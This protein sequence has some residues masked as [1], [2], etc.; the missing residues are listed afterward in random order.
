MLFCTFLISQENEKKSGILIIQVNGLQSNKG[1]VMVALN[2]SEENYSADKNSAYKGVSTDI[3][4]KKATTTFSELPYGFYAVKVFHD[5]NNNDELDLNFVG[6][7]QEPYGF[8]NN[9]RGTFGPASWD[10]ARFEINSDS[11]IISITLE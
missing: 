2:N 8:S 7:P 3:I 6:I 5:V 10:D 9:A 11:L 4:D 1:K